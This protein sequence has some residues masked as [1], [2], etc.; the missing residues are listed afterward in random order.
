MCGGQACHETSC[1]DGADNDGDGVVDAEAVGRRRAEELEDERD[2]GRDEDV[3]EGTAVEPGFT[4]GGPLVRDRLALSLAAHAQPMPASIRRM[5]KMR[6]GSTPSL[7]AVLIRTV[8][9]ST[10]S[11]PVRLLKKPSLSVFPS[12]TSFTMRST[13]ATTTEIY[14]YLRVLFAR[15]G[16]PH[17]WECGRP[18]TSQTPSQ[19][20]DAVMAHGAGAKVMTAP[21]KASATM[22]RNEP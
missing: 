19:I 10:F 21:G 9:S 1:G 18:I 8:A 11:A 16:T 12:A 7:A 4:I 17:C 3:L 13:V 22:S 6:E 14:D 5:V 20:V 15:A 2:P